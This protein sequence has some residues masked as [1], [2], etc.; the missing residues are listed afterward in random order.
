MAHSGA[1]D[2][3]LGAGQGA[4]GGAAA[5]ASVG[6]LFGPMAIPGAII[7]GVAGLGLGILGTALDAKAQHKK[8]AALAAAEE[9]YQKALKEFESQKMQAG[10]AARESVKQAMT[11]KGAS[12]SA[13]VSTAMDQASREADKSGLIGAEKADHIAKVRQQ[14]EQA[15]ASSSPAVYQQALGGAR[16][17]MQL[18]IQKAAIGLQTS[19]GK[20]DTDV[21]Q[22]SGQETS[23]ASAAIGQSLGAV[24]QTAG[25]LHGA[26]VSFAKGGT[27]A[28]PTGDLDVDLAAGDPT[29][30]AV[31]GSIDDRYKYLLP[32]EFFDAETAALDLGPDASADRAAGVPDQGPLP[33]PSGAADRTGVTLDEKVAFL[34]GD[35]YGGASTYDLGDSEFDALL[36]SDSQAGEIPYSRAQ[37]QQLNKLGLSYETG[38]VAGQD[39]PEIVQVGEAGPELV[40]N[41]KQTQQ[42]AQSIGGAP[43]QPAQVSQGEQTPEE[44]EAYLE[45]LLNRVA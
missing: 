17:D 34:G 22:I 2:Y 1:G 36:A 16:Q 35:I 31:Q 9:E 4:L 38:G 20:Y 32:E 45:E 33:V 18:G 14:V 30:K 10:A 27:G 41:A 23:S 6:A 12:D 26:D 28:G 5:G 19:A 43:T 21:T 24:A 44:L 8:E 37:R 40:L 29:A 13:A 11:A 15:R 39:G 3:A 42:L 7:G 25:A